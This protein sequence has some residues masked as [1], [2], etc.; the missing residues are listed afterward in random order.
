MEFLL[1]ALTPR[2]TLTGV[3][4]PV[5]G[6]IYELNRFLY[7]A[8]L[9]LY[10][11]MEKAME[12]NPEYKSGV[13]SLRRLDVSGGFLSATPAA[14]LIPNVVPFIPLDPIGEAERE[15]VLC[16]QRTASIYPCPG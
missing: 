11:S 16:G 12:V 8:A 2:S 5:K 1:V 14:S 13:E 7:F 15:A 9:R 4:I 3:V 10:P 6:P